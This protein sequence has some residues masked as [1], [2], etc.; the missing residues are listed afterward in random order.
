MM[1]LYLARLAMLRSEDIEPTSRLVLTYMAAVALD[2]PS[3]DL[4]A[5]TYYGGQTA[6]ARDL[7]PNMTTK[8]G[9][10]KIKRSFAILIQAG[11]LKDEGVDL[12]QGPRHRYFIDV[13]IG[14]EPLS[15]G[16]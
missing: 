4:P 8:A 2:H 16:L 12:G 7:F 13:S 15:T 6:L 14:G 9:V 10:R 11:L 5:A 3:K 1:G